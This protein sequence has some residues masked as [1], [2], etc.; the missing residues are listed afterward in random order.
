MATE[1]LSPIHFCIGAKEIEFVG[2]WLHL[3]HVLNVTNDDGVDK[4]KIRKALCGQIDNVLCYFGHLSCVLKPKLILT[5]CHSLYG[6]VLWALDHSNLDSLC[7]TWRNGLRH[8]CMGS[9]KLYTRQYF[10][11]SV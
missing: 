6:S 8:I 3:K 11:Y 7:I 5:F 4:D 9:T 10:S 1:R 2:S